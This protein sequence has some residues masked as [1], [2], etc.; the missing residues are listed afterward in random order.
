MAMPKVDYDDTGVTPNF[1][2]EVP[3]PC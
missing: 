3:N 2:F 1:A